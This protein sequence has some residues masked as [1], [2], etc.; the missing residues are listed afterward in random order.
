MMKNCLLALFLITPITVSG[1]PGSSAGKEYAC[2]VGDLGSI[3]GL[4]RSPGEG[5]GYPLHYSGL[6]NSMVSTVHGVAKLDT[7]EV[8]SLSLFITLMVIKTIPK[9]KRC[10][11]AKWLSEEALEILEKGREAKQK[12]RYTHLNVEFQKI[13]RRDKRAF[14]NDQ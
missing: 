5:K 1:F 8:L 3:P 10:K 13:A 7:T 11:K 9:K 12:E 4:G 2:N 14:L 6:E